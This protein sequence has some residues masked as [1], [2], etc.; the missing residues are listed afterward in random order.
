MSKYPRRYKYDSLSDQNIE[1]AV[2]ALDDFLSENGIDYEERTRHKQFLEEVLTEYASTGKD[3]SFWFIPHRSYR[4]IHIQIVIKGK[5]FHI[6]QECGNPATRQ[7]PGNQ[8]IPLKWK[9]GSGENRL[10][11]TWKTVVPGKE[12]LPYVIRYMGK[13][14]TSFKI[15]VIL[16]FVNMLFVI[17]D[18]LWTAQLVLAFNG[19]MTERILLFAVIIA[20]M[21]AASSLVTFIAS[22]M[23][24]RAYTTMHNDLQSDLTKRILKIKTEHI[25]SHG[26]GVFVQRIVDEADNL[27]D[28]IDKTLTIFTETFRMLGLLVATAFISVPMLFFQVILYAVYLIIVHS[29]AKAK[30]EDSR[31]TKRSK[32]NLSSFVTEMIKACRDVKLLH[33]EDKIGRASCRERV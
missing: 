15:G 20:I 21:D 11:Y 8:T 17:V 9:Y 26:S 4:T 10:S 2:A 12:A 3:S 13:E 1:R 16:R 7:K 25:E 27:V 28:G 19:S 32:E 6:A 24:T 29:Q 23:L 5:S 14:K 31:R 18:P 30:S 33:C 22:R